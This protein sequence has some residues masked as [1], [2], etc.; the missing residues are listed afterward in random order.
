MIGCSWLPLHDLHSG[1]LLAAA[2][3]PKLVSLHDLLSG[4]RLPSGLLLAAAAAFSPK[5]VSSWIGRE[6]FWG[7]L[8]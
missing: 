6:W 3:P 7:L 2:L 1:L 4:W 5:L 8:G